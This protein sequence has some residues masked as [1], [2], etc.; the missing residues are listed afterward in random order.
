MHSLP[1]SGVGPGLPLDPR[2]SLVHNALLINPNATNPPLIVPSPA[3]ADRLGSFIDCL[4]ILSVVCLAEEVLEA[5]LLGLELFRL[6]RHVFLDCGG[7]LSFG[8]GVLL[9]VGRIK[10]RYTGGLRV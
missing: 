6:L 1:L 5:P 3:F 4:A 2:F 8:F 10:S 7:S 9:D